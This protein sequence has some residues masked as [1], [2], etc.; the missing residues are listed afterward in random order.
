M[1]PPRSAPLRRRVAAALS[2]A[3][4]LACLTGVTACA[5]PGPERPAPLTRPAR[6]AGESAPPDTGAT[7]GLTGWLHHIGGEQVLWWGG[8][9]L[10]LLAVIAVAALVV[11]WSVKHARPHPGHSHPGPSHAGPLQPAASQ[12]ATSR[13]GP[14]QSG[15]LQPGTSP[16]GAGSPRSYDAATAAPPAFTPPPESADAHPDPDQEFA[17]APT[18]SSRAASSQAGAQQALIRAL[19]YVAGSGASRAVS[20]QIERLLAD[21]PPDRDALVQACIRH[22]DQLSARFP[23]LGERLHD[24]LHTVGVREV[25]AVGRRFDGRVHESVRVTPTTDPAMHDLVAETTRCGY[26]DG[27]RVLRVP[28]VV[29][30]RLA[31]PPR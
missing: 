8:A 17:P 1:Q 28:R 27:D 20:E 6:D 7:G 14:S 5:T 31:D 22:R 16:P 9:V 2:A 11:L 19:E 13:P 26:V 12:P 3:P 29:V 4:V 24:A 23:G 30:Y 10:L 15:T 18:G 25:R 21:G